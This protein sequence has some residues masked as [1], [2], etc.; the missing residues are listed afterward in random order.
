M[1][2]TPQESLRSNLQWDV[3]DHALSHILRSKL[4]QP[5]G[6]L[7]QAAVNRSS[8]RQGTADNRTESR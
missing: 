7:E 4:L 1:V 3:F 2:H 5:G 6:T 8:N